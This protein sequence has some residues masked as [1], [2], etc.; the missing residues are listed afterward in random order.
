M[1]RGALVKRWV[2]LPAE[3]VNF[4]ACNKMLVR[5]AVELCSEF[6]RERY[7]ALHSPE[8]EKISLK[9]DAMQIK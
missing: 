6:W 8:Y 9:K 7:K 1:F 4:R 2:A 5:E 3:I